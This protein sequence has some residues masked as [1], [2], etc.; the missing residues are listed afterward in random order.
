MMGVS[1]RGLVVMLKHSNFQGKPELSIEP[2]IAPASTESTYRGDTK[3]SQTHICPFCSSPLLCHIRL[4]KICWFCRH[5]HQEIPYGVLDDIEIGHEREDNDN[6]DDDPVSAGASIHKKDFP[7]LERA[8]QKVAIAVKK[9]QRY[10]CLHSIDTKLEKLAALDEL[11]QL[12]SRQY[13]EEYLKQEWRRME[14]EQENISLIICDLDSNSRFNEVPG[15]GERDEY[16]QKLA[17]LITLIVKR[18]SDL[19]ARYT[20]EEFAI[21]LPYTEADGAIHVAKKIRGKIQSFKLNQA[22]SINVNLGVSLGVA[23]GTPSPDFYPTVLIQ[24]AEN[25]LKQAKQV[26]GNQIFCLTL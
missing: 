20:E 18:P 16:L 6:I 23:S 5:C 22:N 2:N 25:A 21:L 3:M 7:N 13:F 8:L 17:T 4:G 24:G 26:A 14:G 19:V 1:S 15:E 12:A 9:R 11:T 10:Q